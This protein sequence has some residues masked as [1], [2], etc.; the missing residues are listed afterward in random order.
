MNGPGGDVL[1]R[2]A[3]HHSE[4]AGHEASIKPSMADVI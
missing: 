2:A 3:H 1:G 4:N